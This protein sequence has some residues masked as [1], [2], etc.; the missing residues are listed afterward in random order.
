MFKKTT[1]RYHYPP[2]HPL[3]GKRCQADTPGAVK[4]ETKSRK[5]YAKVK[6]ADG[7]VRVVPLAADK[8][9]ARMLLRELEVGAERERVGLADPHAEHAAAP[10]ADHLAAF[11]AELESRDRTPQHV[12]S[13]VA[14]CRAAL[15]TGCGFRVWGDIDAG[16]L[17]QH[18]AD[19]R[20]AGLGAATSNHYKTALKM[21]TAWMV[22]A[23]RAATDP[24]ARLRGV[25]A[26]V[27]TVIPYLV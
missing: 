2:E 10:L 9:A 4:R 18:L 12:R 1:T 15:L 14:R 16:R 7:T 8:G 13:T 17:G 11:A 21:F 26:W 23:G 19:R 25:N 5:W 27:E 20:R 3:A 6:G 24:L 22:E